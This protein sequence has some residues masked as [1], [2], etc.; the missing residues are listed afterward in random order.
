MNAPV[1][2]IN[3]RQHGHDPRKRVRGGGDDTAQTCFVFRPHS[4]ARCRY[5]FTGAHR[6]LAWPKYGAFRH[7]AELRGDRHRALSSLDGPID[8]KIARLT[9]L[10]RALF[11][12]T[13]NFAPRSGLTPDAANMNRRIHLSQHPL[14]AML[15]RQRRRR[16]LVVHDRA[17]HLARREDS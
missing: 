17:N 14:V 1:G 6:R 7:A 4:G 12:Q 11:G 15:F 3:S 16:R 8:G 13:K 10:S 5:S 2:G 9:I